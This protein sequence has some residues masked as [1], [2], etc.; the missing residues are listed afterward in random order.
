[1]YNI[2]LELLKEFNSISDAS[3]VTG[4]FRSR[5]SRALKFNDNRIVGG[6]IFEKLYIFQCKLLDNP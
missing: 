6:F 4:V 3:A 1:L 5:I 2:N